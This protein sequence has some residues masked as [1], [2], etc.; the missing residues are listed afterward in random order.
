MLHETALSPE[1]IADSL[2]RGRMSEQFGRTELE[3]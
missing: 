3:V 1:V 2:N